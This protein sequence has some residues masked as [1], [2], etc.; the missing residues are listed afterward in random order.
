MSKSELKIGTDDFE[1][2]ASNVVT[3]LQPP[4]QRWANLL[5]AINRVQLT[6]TVLAGV[7]WL[8][9]YLVTNQFGIL[10]VD[11][12]CLFLMVATVL[13]IALARQSQKQSS[14]PRRLAV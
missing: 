11:A 2:T 8:G 10:L 5:L 1:L 9:A 6:L 13:S 12:I 3:P 7:S 4:Y 14:S